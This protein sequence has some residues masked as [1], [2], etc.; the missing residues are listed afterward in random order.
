MLCTKKG[1]LY[2]IAS[3]VDPRFD[4]DIAVNPLNDD[5]GNLKVVDDKL[6]MG[7]YIVN[8][9]SQ[10]GV[11]N[12]ADTKLETDDKELKIILFLCKS[13]GDRNQLSSAGFVIIGRFLCWSYPSEKVVHTLDM[14]GLNAT[15]VE[16]ATKTVSRAM[17][18]LMSGL[19]LDLS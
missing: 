5:D 19:G 14:T 6:S 2:R 16:E 15:G 1:D 10:R 11:G 3:I 9:K 8:S 18:S 7:V 12:Q 13:E 4:D 17:T